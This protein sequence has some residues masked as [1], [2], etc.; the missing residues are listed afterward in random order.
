LVKVEFGGTVSHPDMVTVYQRTKF[1]ANIF[2]NDRNMATV[3]FNTYKN[4]LLTQQKAI[5]KFGQKSKILD[6][7][8]RHLEFSQKCIF[9]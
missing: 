3:A 1:G 8:R 2:I 5:K 4:Q 6:R 9:V 7:G